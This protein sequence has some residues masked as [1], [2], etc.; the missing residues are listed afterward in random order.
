MYFTIQKCWIIVLIKLIVMKLIIF[1]V[2]K[3][4]WYTVHEKLCVSHIK[5]LFWGNINK[6]SW[7]VMDSEIISCDIK[8]FFIQHSMDC[9]QFVFL[10]HAWDIAIIRPYVVWKLLIL[11][12]YMFFFFFSRADHTISPPFIA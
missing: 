4:I 3:K 5:Y 9:F 6:C 8:F 2:F 1:M 11:F 7:N 10:Q 12:L